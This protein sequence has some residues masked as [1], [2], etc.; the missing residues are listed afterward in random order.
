M[1]VSDRGDYDVSACPAL[2]HNVLRTVQFPRRCYRMF[3]HVPVW[4]VGFRGWKDGGRESGARH[5][6]CCG[7]AERVQTLKREADLSEP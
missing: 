1:C 6:E 2:R 4:Q 7:L 5:V 3:M